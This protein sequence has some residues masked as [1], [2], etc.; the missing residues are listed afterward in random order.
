MSQGTP[1][2]EPV[3]TGARLADSPETGLRGRMGAPSIVFMVLACMSPLT[4]A[5]G[6]VGLVIA[7]GNGLGAPFMFLLVGLVMLV[8]AVAYIGLVRRVARPGAF[9]A[10]ITAGL[11]K[12]VGLGGAFLTV[13]TYVLAEIGLLTF[14]GITVS[15][16]VSATFSGL[17]LPW[18]VCAVP[19]LVVAAVLSYLNIAVSARFLGVVLVIELALVLIFDLVVAVSGGHEGVSGE[20]FTFHALT[21]GS[22]PLAFLFSLTLFSGWESTALYYEEMR[23]PQRTIARATYAIVGI[24]ALFYVVTSWMLITGYGTSQAYD[25]IAADYSA[26][27]G[28]SVTKYLGPAINDVANVFLV[29]GLL[30]SVLSMNNMISRYLYSLGVDG[31][32]PAYLGKANERHGSPARASN[33]VTAVVALAV[34]AVVATGTDAN[35]VLALTSGSGT[36]G[37]LIMFLLATIA[38]LIFFLKRPEEKRGRQFAVVVSALVSGLVFATMLVYLVG[39]LD[40]VVGNNAALNTSLQVLVFATFIGG[41][42]YA[43]YLRVAKRDVF[44]EIG[45]EG[46]F[47][48]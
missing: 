38:I 45:R 3:R 25:A 37:F 46:F 24:V 20:P 43:S 16:L 21:S 2:V 40:L 10:Y 42:L 48:E 34:L 33:I 7:G 13:V 35:G 22:I 29:T 31:V 14:G 12:R 1:S 47:E 36:Y 8:F 44:A 28:Q 9:Y 17:E 5:A 23:T 27:F 19:F 32:L 11:G 15:T 41:V 6:Y 26:A 39:N 18:W 4:G 30:A